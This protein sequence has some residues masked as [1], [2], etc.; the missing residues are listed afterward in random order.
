MTAVEADILS[1]PDILRLTL[2]HVARHGERLA[3]LLPV[4][5]MVF[6]GCGSSYGIALAAAALCEARHGLPAQAV[7]ASEYRPRP[8]WGHLAISRT[9]KTTELIEAMAQARAAGAPV[10]LLVGDRGSPAETH[11]DLVLG[12]EFAPEQGV[13][14]TRFVSAA[15][16]AL[17]L[18]I[19]GAQ[20]RHTLADL[21]ERVQSGLAGF[22][23]TALGAR[24]HV[25]FL[26]RRERYGLAR[27]AAL[28]LQE[29]ALLAA[30]GHQTLD[31]RHGPIAS[32]ESDS[33]IWCF[34]PPDDP[35]S[36]GVLDDARRTG[37]AIHTI[38]G[39]PQVALVLAQRAAAHRA[40]RRGID[41]DAPRHLSRAIV[42]P[43]TETRS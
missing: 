6:L 33:L 35:L 3:A 4:Q 29:T 1:T 5:P 11:A 39:D 41:P 21:P 16:L 36:A 43:T 26:G 9:G 27:L 19:G 17:R 10:A 37:A 2:A 23:P 15:L 38:G 34:D 30:E 8:G 7:I 40:T 12:L 20:A 31:Y 42:L 24:E 32:A 14:Q 25:V 18:V 13:I 28:N 22:D